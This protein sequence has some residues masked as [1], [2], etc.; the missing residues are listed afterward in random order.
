MWFVKGVITVKP[1]FGGMGKASA[2]RNG[3]DELKSVVR[4]SIPSKRC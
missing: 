1:L 3:V 2:R 4:Y